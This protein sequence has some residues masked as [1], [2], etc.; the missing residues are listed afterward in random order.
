MRRSAG[1]P[2]TNR[3]LSRFAAAVVRVALP[4][5]RPVA[6]VARRSPRRPIGIE[7]E[8][9]GLSRPGPGGTRGLHGFLVDVDTVDDPETEVL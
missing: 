2:N 1:A 4:T 7:T 8:T 6:G 3:L 9:E 5:V